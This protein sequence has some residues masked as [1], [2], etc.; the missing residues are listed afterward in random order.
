MATTEATQALSRW[1]IARAGFGSRLLPLAETRTNAQLNHTPCSSVFLR[2]L[3]GKGALF[4]SATPRL[5]GENGGC[6]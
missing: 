1:Q 3:W 2:V 6:R 5:R 4:F